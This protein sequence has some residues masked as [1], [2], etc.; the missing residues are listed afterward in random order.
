MRPGT[1]LPRL[2]PGCPSSSFPRT[3]T[4][5]RPACGIGRLL[6]MY[7]EQAKA[8]PGLHC[9]FA[10]LHICSPSSHPKPGTQQLLRTLLDTHRL[11]PEASGSPVPSPCCVLLP[12][13]K[14][15]LSK[16]IGRTHHQVLG[17]KVYRS[18]VRALLTSSGCFS[19]GSDPKAPDE[20]WVPPPKTL[21]SA[22]SLLASPAC[23]TSH[24]PRSPELALSSQAL[25]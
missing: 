15:Y 10:P 3:C 13:K 7:P 11:S 12:H 2:S 21:S 20:T 8:R 1:T 19:H 23:P 24:H 16:T 18:P 9:D 4:A 5:M 25:P 14:L 17:F 22:S 6:S